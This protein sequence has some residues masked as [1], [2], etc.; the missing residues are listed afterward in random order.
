MKSS[1]FHRTPSEDSAGNSI[2]LWE[3]TGPGAATPIDISSLVDEQVLDCK[4]ADPNNRF[5]VATYREEFHSPDSWQALISIE[6]NM[7]LQK[8]ILSWVFVEKYDLFIVT[9]EK[10]DHELYK[11]FKSYFRISLDDPTECCA[12]I[13]SMGN[14][15]IPPYYHSIDYRN[16][17]DRFY[18]HELADNTVGNNIFTGAGKKVGRFT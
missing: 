11:D 9:L 10:M 8:D 16:V 6:N 15:I 12:V 3:Y 5:L 18:A 2:T 1:Q 17:D 4:V 13:N 14:Y 7:L